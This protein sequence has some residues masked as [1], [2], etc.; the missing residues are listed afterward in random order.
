M[1]LTPDLVANG[2]GSGTATI[3]SQMLYRTAYIGVDLNV[4]A[5]ADG[6]FPDLTLGPQC[7]TLLKSA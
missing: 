4:T 1:A 2:S 7:Q 6:K 3:N 5:Y